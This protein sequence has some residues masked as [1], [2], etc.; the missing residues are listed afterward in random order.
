M[1]TEQARRGTRVPARAQIMGWMLLVLVVVLTGIVLLVWRFLHNEAM[2]KV[3]A[4]LE[5]EGHEFVNFAHVGRDPA[6]GVPIGDPE[7]LFETYLGQQ[8][9]DAWEALIGTWDTP[10]GLQMRVQSQDKGTRAAVHD[11]GL[12]ERI[13]HSAAREGTARSS[14]GPLR[15]VKVEVHT[16][17][18]GHAW[19]ITGHFTAA[20]VSEVH[21]VVR[22]LVLVSAFGVLLA[23]ASSWVVAGAILAPVRVVRQTAAEISEHDLTRR[24][25]VEGRD[26]I[27]ALAYQ[28]NAMLD[29]LESA[30]STQ[31]QFVDD[32]SHELRTP[33]TIVRGH[34][35]L[36][37]DD[38]EERDEVVRLCTDEL[39]RMTRIV[40]DLL[41][42]AKADRPDFVHPAEVS[43]AELTSDIDAK[44]RSIADRRWVL[45]SIGE[46]D[47]VV[48]AQ[49]LTQ[50][51]VQLAQNAVQH[52]E[53]GSEIR[54]GSALSLGRLTLWVTD[55][56]PGVDPAE[57]EQIFARFAH[58]SGPGRGGAG[59]GLAIV[60]AI[61]EAHQG[62]V[63]VLSEPGNGATF[64]LDLPAWPGAVPGLVPPATTE[65]AKP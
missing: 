37:G 52:T 44:V 50:A 39:D 47:V 2:N 54:I 17:D 35:E 48:D 62:R 18:G 12:L 4:A 28:F 46:G 56:G 49:R 19:F 30:F 53:D 16:R 32:A 59:L 33:I 61:A 40:E 63:R 27:A 57:V 23:A 38:P 55:R 22:T 1:T 26:D 3:T 10:T 14:A 25:P 36:L 24:I 60:A 8:Y 9:P 34:L 43:L 64:G 7:V 42:L 51:V 5:Q 45:E 65:E 21:E 58:G 15:W 6:T 41:M 13:S 20:D 11:P 31:R 29:R